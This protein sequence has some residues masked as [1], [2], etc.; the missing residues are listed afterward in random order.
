MNQITTMNYENEVFR[1]EKIDK[2]CGKYCRLHN[3]INV[4]RCRYE[5]CA[6]GAIDIEEMESE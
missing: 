4:F 6:F 1:T 3:G 2:T 5:E